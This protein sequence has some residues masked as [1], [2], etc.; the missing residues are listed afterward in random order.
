[1]ICRRRSG[2]SFTMCARRSV[3]VQTKK[4]YLWM[5]GTD[6]L[7]N[8]FAVVRT[9]THARNVD[10]KELSERFSAAIGVEQVFEK[11]AASKRTSK[12]L[13]GTLDHTTT[14]H[15]DDNGPVSN[16]NV[17]NVDLPSCWYDGRRDAVRI[18]Q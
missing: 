3:T 14:H 17:R 16:T 11:N 18:L 12:R 13:N 7:E 10:S 5:A 9:L 4:L 2:P 15:W 6:G 8:L 1:M